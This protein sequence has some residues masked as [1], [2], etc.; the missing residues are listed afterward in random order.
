MAD[1]QAKPFEILLVDDNDD[2]IVLLEES[3]RDDTFVNL[4]HI[5]RVG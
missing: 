2:D 1:E 3:L 4:L 5:A